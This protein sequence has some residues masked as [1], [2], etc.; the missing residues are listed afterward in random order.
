MP[1]STVENYLKA[2]L[3]RSSDSDEVVAMG[4]LAEALDVTPG[5]VTTMVKSMASRGLLEHLPR[6]GVRLTPEGRS[7]ALAVVRKHRL[8]ET[9]LVQ[10]LKMDWKEV[11]QEAEA[12]EHAISDTVLLRI[13][14]LLGYP[15]ADPHG[16]PI[17]SRKSTLLERGRGVT[18]ATCDLMKP[19][20]VERILDQSTPFLEYIQKTGLKPGAKVKVSSRDRASGVVRCDLKG[21][22]ATLGLPEAA[23]IEVKAS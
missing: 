14:E 7:H 11:H 1:T 19:F 18:L 9:F 3:V 8:V 23:K 5:T 17:P 21:G 16:D 12:L 22:E 15:S 4:V 6:E 20:R 13:D 2:I 10:V